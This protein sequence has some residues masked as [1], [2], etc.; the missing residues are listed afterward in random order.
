[1][2]VETKIIK[3]QKERDMIRQIIDKDFTKAV[4]LLHQLWP[5][6]Q[7]DYEEM[8]KVVRKYIKESNYHIYGYEDN[9][10]LLGIITISFR[11]AV[12]YEGKVATIEEL[13]VDQ[14]HQGKGIGK[15]LV[16]FAEDKIIRKH[17]AK[18]IELSSDLRRKSTHEFWEKM[19]YPKLAYQFRRELHRD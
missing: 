1:M 19:G 5:D 12:F 8:R 10:V 2:G 16:K 13:V 18:G 14:A 15:K 3:A 7:I 6:K 4:E 11:W 17:K 9:G